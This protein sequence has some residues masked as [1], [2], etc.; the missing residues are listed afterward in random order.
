VTPAASVL[1]LFD[2][3]GS[4]IQYLYASRLPG[5]DPAGVED[6]HLHR[7]EPRQVRVR[8]GWGF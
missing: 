3:G 6:V 4:D 5:E 8:A 1:N 7:F 2:A